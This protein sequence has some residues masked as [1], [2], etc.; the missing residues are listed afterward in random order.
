MTPTTSANVADHAFLSP[1]RAVAHAGRTLVACS[2]LEH[3]LVCAGAHLQVRDGW[4]VATRFG[5]VA[6]ELQG[7]RCT[8]AVSDRSWLGTIEVQAPAQQLAE[9]AG[10]ALELGR[11][12][13]DDDGD[14]WCPLTPRRLLVVT[15]PS[16]VASLHTR[17]AE[18]AGALEHASVVDVTAGMGAILVVGPRARDLLATLSAL[19]LRAASAPVGALRPGSVARVPAIVLHEREARFLVLFGAA[20]AEYVWTVITDAGEPLQ[21]VL[22]GNDAIEAL[23]A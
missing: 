5:A 9:L 1:H 3:E 17:L 21:A 10:G 11:A 14:W 20:Q 8:V 13:R 23:D 12:R 19:D 4:R 2:P 6:D 22:A 18:A 7:A 15:P 16:R